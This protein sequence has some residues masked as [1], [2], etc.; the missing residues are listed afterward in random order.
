MQKAMNKA[1]TYHLEPGFVYASAKGAVI[2]TV[3]GSCVAVC[4]WDS[5]KQVGGMNHFVHPVT[6]RHDPR[7]TSYGNVALHVLV[8]M[9]RSEF[10][11][12]KSDLQAQIFGGA[13]PMN[14]GIRS[15]GPENVAVARA[16]LGN[17]GIRIVSEDVGGNLGR[18]ILFDTAT[19]QAA[20]LKVQQLR[21]DDWVKSIDVDT[22][23]KRN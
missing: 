16:F 18:K 15:V 9:M 13:S 6:G 12:R 8:K 11:S 3:V 4:L 21:G 5:G 1:V 17:L 14:M 2:R 23:G 7:T 10:G 22:S 20:V 19:G